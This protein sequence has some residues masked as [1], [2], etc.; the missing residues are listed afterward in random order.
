MLQKVRDNLKGTFVAVIV[1]LLFIVPLVLT[2]VGGGSYLG[3]AVGG[4]VASVDGK[5]ISSAELR[6]AIF[7][8][9]QSLLSREG[10]DTEAEFLKDENLRGPV[11]DSLTRRVAVIVSARKGGMGV[12]EST[13][14]KQILQQ[15]E[16]Q[17][18]GKFDP[19]TYRRLL[20]N[21]AYTP[22]SYKAA[23]SEEVLLGQHVAGIE[24]SSFSTEKEL[25]DLVSLIEQRRSFYTVRVSK[26]RVEESVEVTDDD[27]SLYYEENR[28]EYIDEEKMSVEYIELSVDEVA[29]AVEIAD[30]D[31][32]QQYEQE[33]SSFEESE[34]YEIAHLL[35]ENNNEQATL[36]EE[37]DRKIKE[38]KDFSALVTEYSDDGGSSDSGGNLGLM[39]EGIFPESFEKAVY[40][41]EQGQISEPVKT[42]AGIHFIKLIAKTVDKAPTYDV[43]K[44]VIENSLK[45]SEAEQIFAENFDRLGELTF[46]AADL[47]DAAD[48][49]GLDVKTTATF[50]RTQGNDAAG[51]AAFRAAAFAE[52]VLLNGYNSSVVEVSNRRAYVL[53]KASHSPERIKNLEEV[54]GEISQTL[55]DNK[56]DEA[57][58]RLASTVTEKLVSGA[59]P[60]ELAADAG[61]EYKAYDKVVRSSS[62][63]G[64]RVLEKAFSMVLEKERAFDTAIERG[65]NHLVVGLT[66]VLPGRRED[67][68]DQQFDGLTAQLKLQV[69]SLENSTYES[70]IV[71]EADIN[72]H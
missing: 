26:E 6:R 30:E 31:I 69:S 23:L 22:S 42:D 1:F 47:S 40:A 3:S 25:S 68:N 46:N 45:Q 55:T 28:S 2:G 59:N 35:I 15:P 64:F 60:E 7:I 61:Y 16:F 72:I 58:E 37:V 5:S 54:K 18:G 20:N 12:A 48:A 38:G 8:R 33:I 13:V 66:E 62:D 9:K 11:L 57:L 14:D 56:V 10:V 49:L 43:R 21:L 50:S 27:I 51:N 71:E 17:L 67:M 39:T 41:L 19:Q 36:V 24:L 52:E 44:N 53:R 70:Q 32:R 4:D 63:A 29:A 34:A 65:G